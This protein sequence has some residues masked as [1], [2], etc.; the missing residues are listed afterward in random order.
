MEL[1]FH[2]QTETRITWGDTQ[3]SLCLTHAS[4]DPYWHLSLLDAE[5]DEQAWAQFETKEQAIALIPAFLP[6]A[7]HAQSQRWAKHNGTVPQ[8]YWTGQQFLLMV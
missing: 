1:V 5:D 2:T 8:A 6:V 7:F 3:A 4:G